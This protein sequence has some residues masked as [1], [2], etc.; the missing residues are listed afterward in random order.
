MNVSIEIRPKIGKCELLRCETRFSFLHFSPK[1]LPEQFPKLITFNA[2]CS[3]FAVAAP[4]AAEVAR[5]EA[6]RV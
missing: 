1:V 3:D 6:N 5:A 2:D 4:L